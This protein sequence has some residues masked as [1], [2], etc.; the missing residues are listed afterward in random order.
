MVNIDSS[1]ATLGSSRADCYLDNI[2]CGTEHP[3]VAGFGLQPPYG[4]SWESSLLVFQDKLHGLHDK[5]T[6]DIQNGRNQEMQVLMNPD[7]QPN[8]SHGR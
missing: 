3:D 2:L 4:G 5:L 1:L 6:Q 8:A 7:M